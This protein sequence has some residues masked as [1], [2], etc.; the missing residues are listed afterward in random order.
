MIRAMWTAA[1]GMTAQQLNVDTI[2]HNLA[3][4]NTNAFKRSR[5]EF[6]DLLYQI[7]RMPGTNASSIGIFP[8]GMQVGGGVRPTTVAKEWAQGNLRQTNN[9][10]D[11][12]IDGVGFFQV[13]RSDGSIMYTRNGSFKRDNVGN[14]VTGDGDQLTPTITVPS[15][16][17]KI[18]IGQDGTVSVLLPGVTQAS[19]VG[20]I[21]LTRFDNPAGL[22][23]VGNNLFMDSFASGPA[24]QG[25]PGFSTGFGMLQQGFLESSNV[26]LAE[27]MVN[28]IIAQRSYEINS[29]TI[30]A[31]DEMMSMAN[32]LRR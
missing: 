8:V 7:Q 9:E 26:N 28:L 12:A 24:I 3:N 17:L 31:S 18:D 10:L 32:N 29:K 14:L 13:Q 21:Q 25:V 4:V 22:V 5:A 16:A 19:Q 11:L 27:E 23:A 20:Q 6:A 2:A 1:T 15:G 30:Q